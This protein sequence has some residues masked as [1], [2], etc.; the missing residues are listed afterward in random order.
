VPEFK[1]GKKPAVKPYGLAD[2]ATYSNGKLPKP[3][4]VVE[5]PVVKDWTVLGNDVYGDCT[6]AGAAHLVMA[7]NKEVKVSDEVPNTALV[8]QTYFTLSGGADSGL[9]EKTVLTHW[10]ENGLW[11]SKISGFAPVPQNDIT[12]IRQAIAFYGGLYV[13]VQLPKS[14]EEQFAR[15]DSWSVEPNSPIIGGHCIVLVGYDDWLVY[16]VTWGKLIEIT[17]PWLHT[18]VDEAWAIL[19]HEFIEA[20]HGPA[21]SIDLK[22]LQSDLKTI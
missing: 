19:P 3:P 22:T 20:G 9:V 14:A 15:G 8:E 6:I 2:L 11:G 16:A 12:Q 13:G 5:A 10:Y 1:L 7:W 17:W 21:T 4:A 18:Y